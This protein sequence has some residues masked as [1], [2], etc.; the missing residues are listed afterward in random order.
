MPYTVGPRQTF[1]ALPTAEYHLTLK[2]WKEV[3]EQSDTEFSKKGDV[4]VQW[5]WI[6]KVP[7]LDDQERRDWTNIPTSF[8]DKSNFVHIAIALRIVDSEKAIEA[9]ATIDP[10]QGIGK[11]CLGTIVKSLKKD[12]KTWTDKITQYAPLPEAQAP[13]KPKGDM[14]AKLRERLN[15]LRAFAGETTDTPADLTQQALRDALTLIGAKPITDRAKQTLVEQIELA[16]TMGIN[17]FDDTPTPGLS[18]KD[19]LVLYEKVTA[20]LDA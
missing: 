17:D 10:D 20:R 1:E 3:I 7:N 11:S 15:T 12:N 16:N 18:L 5:D 9:G 19:A 6:V 13:A 4:R 14:V 8:S 2:S